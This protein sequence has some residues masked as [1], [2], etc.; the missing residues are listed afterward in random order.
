VP[1]SK[2]NLKV[3][4][5]VTALTIVVF[6]L[7][8]VTYVLTHSLS[9]LSDTLESVVNIV[10]TLVGSYS[11]FIASK[12]KDKDHPYGHGKAEFVSAAFQGSLIVG[13]GCLIMYKAID[14]FIHPVSLHNLNNGIWLLVVIA[15]INLV[16][17]L[18]LNGIGKKNKSLAILSSGKL[19][20]IDFFTTASVAIGILLL[21]VTG[22]EKIDAIIALLLGTYVIYDGYK[23]VRQSLAGIMDEA[24]MELLEEV[25]AEINLSRNEK[26]IDLHNLR[27]IKYG[28]LLHIDCH[29]T[30]PWYYNVN[31]AHEAVDD[32]TRLIK[33]KF[34]DTVEFYIHTDGCMPFSCPICTIDNCDKR[35]SPFEKKLKWNLENVL[36]DRKHQ[37]A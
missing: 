2:Q 11:L 7:K 30:V 26:W 25:I 36:S 5:F 6:L 17:A 24:D 37:L 32:F 20:Q 8:V 12:P 4:Y 18:F 1:Y 31:Q 34:G 21:I 23:I 10:A 22:Y 14:S 9:V 13:I 35:K 3:Q 16:T 27:V 19:F 28:A 33:N 29:L 15:V